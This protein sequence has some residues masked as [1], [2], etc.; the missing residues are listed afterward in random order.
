[1]SVAHFNFVKDK[2]DSTKHQKKTKIQIGSDEK[3]EGVDRRFP[4]VDSVVCDIDAKW[5]TVTLAS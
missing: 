2:N 3:S 4:S 5:E 1:M